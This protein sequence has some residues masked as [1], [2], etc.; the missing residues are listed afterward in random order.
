MNIAILSGKGGTGKTT[1]ATNLAEVL[2]AN[3]IDCD[4]E[5]PNGFIFL[6]PEN[7]ETETV[8]VE[9][10]DIDTEKCNLCSDCTDICQFNALFNTKKNIIVFE[11]MCHSCKA[12]SIGCKP[13]AITFQPRKVGVIERGEKQGL[14][15]M[16]GVLNIGEAMAV[17]VIKKL[18]SNT[19]AGLN[20]LDC[21][22]GTSCN[23]VSTL[24]HTQAA[25]LVTEPSAFGL[26]DL[27]MAICLVR[28][29]GLPFGVIINK[30]E[31]RTGQFLEDY[32]NGEGINI[33]G[34]IPY[35]RQAAE[36]YST[37]GMVRKIPAYQQAFE[38]IVESGREVFQWN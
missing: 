16:R 2:Q 14:I 24:R 9:C 25:L 35:N 32:L 6:K 28:K 27:R 31:E 19:P 22:P 29:F 36:V 37:G 11:K 8:E 1:V 18:L 4:V 12:C 17:P 20:L 23:A 10:P 33:M 38:K 7:I 13:Q 26:H 30:W 21:S 15:C 34:R 5:E 3:Y